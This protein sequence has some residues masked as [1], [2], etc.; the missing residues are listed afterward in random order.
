MEMSEQVL[1][2]SCGPHPT[3]EVPSSHGPQELAKRK[4]GKTSK[5]Q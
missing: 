5:K 1:N 3:A 4:G 2:H